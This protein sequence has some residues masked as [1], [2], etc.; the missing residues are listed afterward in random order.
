MAAR[1]FDTERRVTP[2]LMEVS[3]RGIQEA[4]RRRFFNGSDEL[5]A[6]GRTGRPV[7]SSGAR[8]PSEQSRISRLV[9]DL[10]VVSNDAAIVLLIW[11]R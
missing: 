1:A 11:A 2:Y 9:A 7:D 10:G 3:F 6:V 8:D 4:E 5:Q